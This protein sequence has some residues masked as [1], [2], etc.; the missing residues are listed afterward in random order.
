M[1]WRNIAIVLPVLALLL[2]AATQLRA[3]EGETPAPRHFVK[4]PDAPPSQTPEQA[5]AKS[6]GCLS[7]HTASDA[8]SMHNSD[9]VVLGCTDC[10][11]GDAH[12]SAPAGLGKSEARYAAL[13]DAAH[14]LPRYPAS[15]NPQCLG[16][17]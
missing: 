3:G 10:H 16:P 5:E 14:V 1:G 2:A 12:V 13:R 6:A 15:W 4:A 7:C 11:G 17:L 9:A 8:P